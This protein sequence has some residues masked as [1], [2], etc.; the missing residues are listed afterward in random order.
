MT[1]AQ[2]PAAVCAR[3]GMAINYMLKTTGRQDDPEF[4]WVHGGPADHDPVLAPSSGQPRLYCDFCSAPD[5]GWVIDTDQ[6]FQITVVD[7]DGGSLTENF[8]GG[9]A[10]C[11]Q[12][13]ELVQTG[14]RR[15]LLARA[16]ASIPFASASEHAAYRA[17]AAQVHA[18]F[19]TSGPQPPQ[20]MRREASPD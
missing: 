11:G 17:R 20:R 9:W 10:A 1:G 14:Q 13:A 15:A 3:C 7:W 2:Q 16:V 4:V 19:F 8:T 12:C 5:P 18:A 6:D